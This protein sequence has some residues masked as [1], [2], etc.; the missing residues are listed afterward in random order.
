MVEGMLIVVCTT[1][2]CSISEFAW[3]HIIQCFEYIVKSSND[4][5]SGLT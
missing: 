3:I 5:E 2:H 4:S 1:L